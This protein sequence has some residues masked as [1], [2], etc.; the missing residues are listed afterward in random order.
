MSPIF[1]SHLA[2]EQQGLPAWNIAASTLLQKA[3]NQRIWCFY[4]DLGAGKTTCI[5]ALCHTLGVEEIVTSPSFA[6]I[7]EYTTKQGRPIYH[8]D[9]YRLKSL[10]EALSI[11]IEE[12]LDSGAYCFIEWA[13]IIQDILPDSYMELTLTNKA[14]KGISIESRFSIKG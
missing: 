12:Y 11:G 10:A 14:T 3:G 4:G 1:I 13:E 2:Y 7:N 9:L 8:F 6:L 5:K